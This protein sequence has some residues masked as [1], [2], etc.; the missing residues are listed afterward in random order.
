MNTFT[1]SS[2]FNQT[3]MRRIW[4]IWFVRRVLPWLVLEVAAA[5]L[6][7]QKFAEYVF[8]NRVFHNATLHTINRS[9]FDIFSFFTNAF[10]NTEFIVQALLISSL[11]VGLLFVKQLFKAYMSL[12][13]SRSSNFS[14]L[15]HVV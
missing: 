4:G 15:H 13:S 10:F 8:V 9:P 2:Q 1:P 7:L 3:I 11:A 5:A 12:L 14:R 6:V